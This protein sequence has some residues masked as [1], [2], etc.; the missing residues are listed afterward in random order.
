MIYGVRR[1]FFVAVLAVCVQSAHGLDPH[2]SLNQYGRQMW[3]TDNGLPQN[4]V[5]AV[6]QTP[7][8]YIWLGTDDGLVRFNGN[9][10]TVFHTENTPQLGSNS[11]QTLVVDHQNRLWVVTTGGLTLYSERTFQKVETGLPTTAVWFVHEDGKRRIWVATSGGLCL[12]GDSPHE[13]RCEP[14]AATQGLSVTKEDKFAEAPNGSIWLADGDTTM[15]L[16]GDR[17]ERG[18]MLKTRDGAEILVQRFD[19]AGRL[20]VGTHSGLQ[21][22]S[23]GVLEPIPIA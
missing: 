3:Q 22:Q 19:H 17:L 18:P 14:V 9:E 13:P 15:S 6:V 4:T 20:L 10:F 21:A 11:I 2:R 7:D 5:H 8:G 23:H 1:W 12:M 16:L